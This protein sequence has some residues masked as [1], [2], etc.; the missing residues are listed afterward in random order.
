MID[1]N[2]SRFTGLLDV[3]L[4][5]RQTKSHGDSRM[6]AVLNTIESVVDSTDRKIRLVPGYKKKLGDTILSSLEFS[7]D[8]VN[9]IPPPL[10]V[11]SSTFV[12][13]PYVN[14]FF[15]NVADLQSVF[16][17]SSEIQDFMAESHEECDGCYALLCMRRTEKTV[18][19]M[20]LSGDRLNKDVLQVTVSFSDHRLYSPA[21]SEPEA[22]E[23]L[24]NCL[25]QGLVTNALERIVRLRLASHQLQSKHRMLHARLRR[26]RQKL[27]EMSQNANIGNNITR[28]IEETGV[29][30]RKVEEQILDT[31]LMT[32]Q[33]ILEQVIEV[34]SNPGEF[35]K[36]RKISLKLNKMGIK[37][38]DDS[39]AP[40]NQLDLTEVSIGDELPRVVTLAQ[41]PRKELLS[42]TVF[43]GYQY[44]GQAAT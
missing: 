9:R 21:P 30:L 14:A 39:P 41:F 3:L 28:A 5:N 33:A 1:F 42:G 32:P 10:E 38:S 12:S 8:L 17:H 2:G 35:V 15:T 22:R 19:G 36:M 37:I 18:L 43:P 29:E 6:A 26:H 20:E 7:D 13:D 4:R 25:F 27:E 16:S 24:K 11:S 31:P 23:G 44:Q 34:L 40:A